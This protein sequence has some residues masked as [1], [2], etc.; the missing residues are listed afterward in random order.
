MTTEDRLVKALAVLLVLVLAVLPSLADQS[1]G[2]VF[3]PACG[4]E[5][6]VGAKFCTRCGAEL[7]VG[8][9]PGEP[10][11]A[12][13]APATSVLSEQPASEPELE[14]EIVPPV[15]PVLAL[16][17]QTQI[18]AEEL[19]DQATAL[20][21]RGEYALAAGSFRQVVERYPS[22][23]CAK[24]ALAMIEASYK[25]AAVDRGRLT[26]PARVGSRSGGSALGEGFVGGCL[27]VGAAIALLAALASAAH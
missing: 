1:E 20:F 27:G 11:E 18:R 9:P 4:A 5:L 10:E 3:C 21:G 6:P 24:A 16:D 13:S 7:P 17:I 14:V 8:V 15:Q 19:F 2:S 12:G 26:R 22:T 23:P 25:M